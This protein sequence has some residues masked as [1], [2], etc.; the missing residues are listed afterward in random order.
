MIPQIAQIIFLGKSKRQQ[1]LKIFLYPDEEIQSQIKTKIK[2]RFYGIINTNEYL[3]NIIAK[4][5]KENIKNNIDELN[6]LSSEMFLEKIL[7]QLN[8]ELA[9]N[10]NLEKDKVN[11]DAVFI[12]LENNEI[13][14]SGCGEIFPILIR[15]NENNEKKLGNIK[16]G[17]E[18]ENYKIINLFE[19]IQNLNIDFKQGFQNIITGEILRGDILIVN[20][21]CLWEYLNNQS[22][23]E[24]FLQLPPKSAVEFVKNKIEDSKEFKKEI[25]GGLLVLSWRTGE[26]YSQR[27]KTSNNSNESLLHLINSAKETEKILTSSLSDIN[28][29]DTLKSII[30]FSKDVKKTSIPKEDAQKPNLKTA[31]PSHYVNPEKK[32]QKKYRFFFKTIAKIFLLILLILKKCL[33]FFYFV[34]INLTAII[35]NY[36]H[37]REKAIH[38]LNNKINYPLL[39]IISKFNLLPQRSKNFL[40]ASIALMVLFSQSVFIV[41]AQLRQKLEQEK[42]NQTVEKIHNNLSG[43]EASLIYKDTQTAYNLLQESL[44]LFET[45]PR[46]TKQDRILRTTLAKEIDKTRFLYQRASIIEE[47]TIITF[48]EK[49]KGKEILKIDDKL[50][51]LTDDNGVFIVKPREEK[52]DFVTTIANKDDALKILGA[53]DLDNPVDSKN[54]QQPHKKILFLKNNSLFTLDI[55]NKIIDS[56]TIKDKDI[57][58]KESLIHFSSP[59]LYILD[60]TTKKFLKIIGGQKGFGKAINY[61]KDSDINT[62][63]ILAFTS[64]AAIYFLDKNNKIIKYSK[65][66][67]EQIDWTPLDPPLNISNSYKAMWTSQES[68]FLYILDPAGKRLIVYNKNGELKKQYISPKFDDLKAFVVNEKDK[69]I[70]ILN[71]NKIY[72]IVAEHLSD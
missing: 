28:I 65:G 29:K 58:L 45:L 54:F 38:E 21:K 8:S 68:L 27:A 5:I 70:F 15:N 7:K 36:Q 60:S 40:V 44:N 52:I 1:V 13:S 69:E 56:V 39:K 33:I 31:P 53:Y 34:L 63:D 62:E 10:K 47:P 72:G 64:D 25:E 11:L 32:W 57:N 30:K 17:L 12:C 19:G 51:V 37:K 35:F 6:L 49:Q 26:M 24:Y 66:Q 67:Q 22:I 9:S 18:S 59:N 50:I 43:I 46:K 55:E 2:W 42:I 20:T 48:F 16:V 71:G 41:N 23:F 14:I 61:F 4:S 3:N